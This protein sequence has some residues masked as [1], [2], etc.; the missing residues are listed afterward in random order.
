MIHFARRFIR[1]A[2]LSGHAKVWKLDP[3][4]DEASLVSQLEEAANLLRDGELVAFPTETVYG[5]G[6]N[7]LSDEAVSKIYKA[8]G[9]PSDNPLIVHIA[10]EK[11]LFDLAQPESIS[12]KAT[13]L[14][15]AF[16]P[17]PLSIVVPAKPIVS[18]IVRAG[19]PT[20]AVRMPSHPVAR[21]LLLRAQ[22]PVA[23]PSA[24]LSGRPSPTTAEH[25]I[26]DL[27]QRIPGVIDAGAA[28]VGLE[29]TV[30][31]VSNPAALPMLLRPGGI[32]QE[33]IE[34]VIGPIEVDCTITRDL[35]QLQNANISQED[36][37]EELFQPRAPGMKYTHYAPV[38]PLHLV[39]GSLDYLK[40]LIAEARQ[41]N[42][43]VGVLTTTENQSLIDADVVVPC[44]QRS[45]LVSVAQKL[46]DALR[47]FDHER[48]DMI[49]SEMFPSSGVGQAIMNRLSKAASHHVLHEAS[50]S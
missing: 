47:V 8:K 20:V 48:V 42:L 9:R 25:V 14:M 21:A 27:G 29:S 38:A 37:H 28:G 24:N 36:G 44:G 43:R 17:G 26:F 18:S 22:V 49:F 31:D 6:A 3:S 50:S 15:R 35:A 16:W 12:E 46:Y 4:N 32:T 34:A 39:D 30:V 11:Q 41:R 5:L 40:R 7:A 1:M 19:L 10:E 13:A 45:D 23:A 33:E 2:Q